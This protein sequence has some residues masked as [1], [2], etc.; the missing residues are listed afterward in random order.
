MI[1]ISWQ[2]RVS[3]KKVIKMAASSV[4]NMF[5]REQGAAAPKSATGSSQDLD[6]LINKVILF[7]IFICLKMFKIEFNFNFTTGTKFLPK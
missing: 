5:S 6:A 4:A 2:N 3:K 1:A 7:L